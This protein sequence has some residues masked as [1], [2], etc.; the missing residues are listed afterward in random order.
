MNGM[1]IGDEARARAVLHPRRTWSRRPLFDCLRQECQIGNWSIG[2]HVFRIE[3][4]LFQ[5]WTNNRGFQHVWE[6]SLF[7][8]MLQITDN[9]I[10][11][12]KLCN[13][14]DCIYVSH[15]YIYIYRLQERIR[16]TSHCSVTSHCSPATVEIFLFHPVQKLSSWP[17]TGRSTNK[18]GRTKHCSVRYNL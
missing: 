15:I 17:Y 5:S 8:C 18:I 6:I 11:M 7:K 14:H 16:W 2:I 13:V 3:I 12:N 10:I 1:Q 9:V 4:R